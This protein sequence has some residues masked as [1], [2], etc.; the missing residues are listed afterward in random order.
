MKMGFFCFIS[1]NYLW[2]INVFD[3]NT[4][5][6]LCII[7]QKIYDKEEEEGMKKDNLYSVIEK[8]IIK[9]LL[10]RFILRLTKNDDSY[11]IIIFKIK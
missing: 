11:V 10:E 3:Q 2:P 1:I 6:I 5:R 4:L 9:F 7:Q 8:K